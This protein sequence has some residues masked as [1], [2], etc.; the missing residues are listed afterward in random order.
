M[1]EKQ[2]PR[3]V[4]PIKNIKDIKRIKQYLLGKKNKRDYLLFVL[5]INVGLRIGDLLSLKI[6]DVREPDTATIKNA[7]YIREQKTGKF[8]EFELNKAAREAIMFYLE[9]LP[10]YKKDD[11]LFS[12]R[13]GRGP[14]TTR[15][16]HKIIKTTL[17]DLDIK[18]NYGTHS[19]RKTF[20]Y[21]RYINNVKLETLQRIFNHNSPA[22]TLRYIGITKE[23]II[24]AYNSV[25]L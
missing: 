17:R 3:E 5:G 10:E 20:G 4:E 18:G 9:S 24:D 1:I 16:A 21:H 23:V 6:S 11:Y 22:T 15:A 19:L 14:I 7:V 8:R 2:L 25:N 12:S 13:K